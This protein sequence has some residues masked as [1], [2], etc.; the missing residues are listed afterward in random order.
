MK[1]TRLELEVMGEI[2]R[3]GT[4][5]VREICDVL[6]EDRR[7]AYTT[8]QTIVL[9]L[10]QKGAVERV[11]KSGNANRYRAVVS[12][13]AA[14]KKIIDELVEVFG[15]SATPLVAQ[16]IEDG[17]LTLRD[18]RALENAASKKSSRKGP[19]R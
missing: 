15:G 18:V 3:L 17:H 5:T 1:L 16:L 9:R 7:P 2:W 12:K 4:C 6:A 14:I 13:R 10:E 8:V 11:G 19:A